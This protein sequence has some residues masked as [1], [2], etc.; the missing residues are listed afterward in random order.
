M[1]V[2]L[3]NVK[4]FGFDSNIFRN[5][6]FAGKES[7]DYSVALYVT[8][9]DKAVI[10]SYLYGKV[11][12][13]AEGEN[14]FYGK[15]KQ[16]I[17]VFDQEKNRVPS[18]INEVFLADVSILIDEFQPADGDAIRYSKCLGIKYLKK[19]ENEQP[20]LPV[21]T[22]DTFDDIF[23]D[24]ETLVIEQPNPYLNG[25]GVPQPQTQPI[26]NNDPLNVPIG[27][28]GDDLPF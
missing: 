19:V 21:K 17:P 26:V 27:D 22:F 8:D 23:A 9:D 7:K 18:P 24:E 10:D 12:V 14:I 1:K 28:G 2:I 11:S 5:N 3:K 25:G 16:P 6:S 20:K 15:S 13:N 4:I